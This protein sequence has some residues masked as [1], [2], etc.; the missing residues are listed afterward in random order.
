MPAVF[1][2]HGAPTLPLEDIPVRSF[3]S[4]L[5][6][7]YH[8]ARAVLCIS[9]HWATRQPAVN[10]ANKPETIHDF[11]GFPD[12]LYRMEYP[13]PGSAEL[14]EEVARLLREAGMPCD[15]DRERGLDHGAWVPLMLMFPHA[16]VPASGGA[17]HP[18][19]YAPLGPGLARPLRAA[20]GGHGGGVAGY[21][22]P[23]H[24]R[25]LAVGRPVH[26]GLRVRLLKVV[27]C[28]YG[29]LDC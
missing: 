29:K 18:L 21:R 2:S 12:E 23:A 8:D 17:V 14:A 28:P 11:A 20:A 9:A 6:E 4:G 26:G 16:E 19:G 10:A 22:R 15:V 5:G 25:E 1:V 3:L 7:R 24:P 13:A 27:S